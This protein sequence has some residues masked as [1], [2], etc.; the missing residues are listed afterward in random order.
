[1]ADETRACPN[2]GE[3]LPADVLV[4]PACS[5]PVPPLISAPAPVAAPPEPKGAKRKSGAPA[6]NPFS[7]ELARRL[8]R[9]QQWQEAA[10]PLDVELP[11]LPKW[12]EEAARTA[13]NPEQWAEAVRGVERLAQRRVVGALEEWE[14]QTKG[15]LG[16][17][18]AYSVDSR[19][20]RDQIEDVLHSART[21]DISQALA[22]YQQVDRV[23]ALKE[24]HLD[25]AREELERIVALLTDMQALGLQP[26][27]DPKEIA[28]DLEREL[29][30]GRL[31]ALK[32]QIRALKLQCV[33][34][35][36]VGLPP[37]VTDY[38]NRLLQERASGVAIEREA[39]E[40]ARGARDFYKGHPEEALRRLR[41]LAQTHSVGSF[42]SSRPS[43]TVRESSRRT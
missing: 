1:M 29:R 11:A 18:E 38:S 9:L 24:R 39:M 21:G 27:Q 4:C 23:V 15:R 6:A 22:T 25:Q 33:N 7:A 12:A 17:L 2:C 36:K 42:R 5:E 13:A 31:A 28:E 14:R 26:P 40:L 3:S 8:A 30:A 37:F 34:R 20:E 19:L 10:A 32:Q 41:A 16:R 43:E 35:L